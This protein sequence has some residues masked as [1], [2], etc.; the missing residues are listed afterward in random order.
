MGVGF[1]GQGPSDQDNRGDDKGNTGDPVFRMDLDLSELVSELNVAPDLCG[2]VEEYVNHL[3]EKR[4]K[5]E[6]NDYSLLESGKLEER[7]R[8]VYVPNG[9][10]VLEQLQ[11]AP[12]LNVESEGWFVTERRM[13][14]L[15]TVTSRGD[16]RPLLPDDRHHS[17][18]ASNLRGES[19]RDW[20]KYEQFYP[21]TPLAVLVE[22]SREDNQQVFI[23]PVFS[24]FA[25]QE[26]LGHLEKARSDLSQTEDPEQ[27]DPVKVGSFLYNNLVI[28]VRKAILSRNNSSQLCG[29][30]S[31]VDLW[32]VISIDVDSQRDTVYSVTA[33]VM[34]VP[35]VQ[36][37]KLTID[38][39]LERHTVSLDWNPLYGFITPKWVSF[40]A[41]S[42]DSSN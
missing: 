15:Y 9:V 29:A 8:G 25:R 40:E 20:F 18:F 24:K 28:S 21:N 38:H 13:A 5:P 19:A 30:E 27:R 2:Y 35:H 26:A 6:S 41:L 31:F 14:V 34:K 1:D 10:G 33:D 16:S 42:S 12:S 17:R 37:R 4:C 39:T 7:L 23:R 3:P 11:H 32:R 22:V 36:T